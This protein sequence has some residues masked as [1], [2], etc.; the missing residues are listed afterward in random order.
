MKHP[1]FV[2]LSFVVLALLIVAAGY[3]LYHLNRSV[4][5][6]TVSS[7]KQAVAE[8]NVTPPPPPSPCASNN[9]D[10]V[11]IVGLNQQHLWACS[12]NVTSY[13]TPVVTGYT[14]LAA[15]VTPVGNYQIFTKETNVN[16]TGSDG[17]S[18]WNVHVSYWMP[19][20]FNKYGAYGFH[21]ATWRTPSE[22]GHVSTST[23]NASHGCVEMPLGGAQW[24]FNWAQVGTQ[25]QIEQSA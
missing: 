6:V 24:L 10:K 16:L 14:G 2:S 7:S 8:T 19:F 17:I 11:I 9:I 15:D 1:R 18:S 20:L 25:I 23:E 5:A 4:N 22:F 3:D 12:F 21:D 13:S